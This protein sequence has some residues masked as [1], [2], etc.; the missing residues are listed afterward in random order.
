MAFFGLRTIIHELEMPWPYCEAPEQERHHPPFPQRG[1]LPSLARVWCNFRLEVFP[2]CLTWFVSVSLIF[3]VT[4][5]SPPPTTVTLLWRFGS[6]AGG[7]GGDGWDLAGEV[8][9]RRGL[10]VWVISG[11]WIRCRCL[12]VVIERPSLSLPILLVICTALSHCPQID[13]LI[14]FP[15]A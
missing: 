9:E 6:G 8:K 4:L 3:T 14:S 1:C 10:L 15:S 2:S 7:G 12:A 5:N 11:Q 13:T